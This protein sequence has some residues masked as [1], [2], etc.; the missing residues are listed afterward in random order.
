MLFY[1]EKL[2]LRSFH[3]AIDNDD[4][5]VDGRVV[6]IL[7]VICNLKVHFIMC[8]LGNYVYNVKW[9]FVSPLLLIE[10]IT[11]YCTRKKFTSIVI[12]FH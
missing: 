2:G 6:H 1:Q 3:N 10:V 9:L 12:P 7:G 8:L 5:H 4:R 11:S